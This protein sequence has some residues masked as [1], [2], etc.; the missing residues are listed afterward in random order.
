M[1]RSL[2]VGAVPLAA[3]GIAA[4]LAAAV[5]VAGAAGEVVRA[6]NV[7]LSIDGGIAPKK[8]PRHKPAP[9]ALRV[10]GGIGTADGTHVPALKT[11]ELQFDRHGSIDTKGLATCSPRKL[12]ATL[13]A[14]ALK[15]CRSALVGRGRVSAEIALPEQAPFD[16]SGPLLIFN[17]PPKGGKKVL[18][19]HVYANVPAPT[20]FVTTAV[21]SKAHGR[22][23][24]DALIRIPTIVGGQGSLTSFQATLRRAW[25]HKGRKRNLL[26][27][28]CPSGALFAHGAFRFADDS[29]IS[30]NIAAPCTPGH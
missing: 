15:A 5:W 16:A 20:T 6:G 28:S 9:I 27:A 18:V 25:R 3:L 8:L 14:R 13:T 4:L 2:P 30:G 26:S 19:F 23:G 1:K 7:I 11:I 10:K 24:T 29:T 17:G 22:F 12:Q 21:I